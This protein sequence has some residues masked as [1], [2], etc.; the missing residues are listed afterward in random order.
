MVPDADALAA[1]H[2]DTS[3]SALPPLV[4][5]VA[6]G[7]SEV[8]ASS[9]GLRPPAGD[10]LEEQVNDGFALLFLDAASAEAHLGP[11]CHPAPLGNVVKL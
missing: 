7:K 2:D 3:S 1:D 9:A 10:L 4:V 6:G 11:K 8:E 5:A